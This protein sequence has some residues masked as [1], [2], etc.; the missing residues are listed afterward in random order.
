M[1]VNKVN[2]LSLGAKLKFLTSGRP[3]L[4]YGYIN[5][6]R[7]AKCIVHI[8]AG[9][10]T[11]AAVSYVSKLWEHTM[12]KNGGGGRTSYPTNAHNVTAAKNIPLEATT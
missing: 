7:S 5:V 1:R 6:F 4:L 12:K 9:V 8:Q 10:T 11:A 2:L 3:L